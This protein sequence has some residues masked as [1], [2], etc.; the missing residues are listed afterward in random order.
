MPKS[1]TATQRGAKSKVDR[2]KFK[3]GGRKS[4]RSAINMT[5]D[6][7]LAAVDASNTRGRDRQLMRRVL[8]SRGVH[9]KTESD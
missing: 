1:R 9:L 6:E 3:V 8:V 7:L 2:V 4:R 5:T